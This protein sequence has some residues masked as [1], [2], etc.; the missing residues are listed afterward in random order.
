M[1][2]IISLILLVIFLTLWIE[3]WNTSYTKQYI[4]IKYNIDIK[5]KKDY[6]MQLFISET[7]NEIDS[8]KRL[9]IANLIE[10]LKYDPERIVSL[11]KQI[12]NA[13]EK[14]KWNSYIE[15]VLNLLSAY[16]GLALYEQYENEE[17]DEIEKLLEESST[18]AQE[19]INT[20]PKDNL[21]ESDSIEKD[22]MYNNTC[23]F[24]K[25]FYLKPENAYCTN[26]ADTNNAWLCNEWYIEKWNKCIDKPE[27]KVACNIKWNISFNSK[28]KVYYL[29]KCWRYKDV[30]IH[31]QYW[32]RWFCSE[33]EA[34]NAWF[35][36]S[37]R[38]P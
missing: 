25:E 32:E 1:K 23:S 12:N 9:R 4:S 15:E 10:T 30:K 18:V 6:E 11:F 29:P 35:I 16:I 2:K 24:N 36:K 8:K 3:Y 28:T 22:E 17:L 19:K 26:W 31:T 38:C 5:P 14:Y 20:T 21:I 37:Y 27:I 13:E 34:I 33:K 7:L